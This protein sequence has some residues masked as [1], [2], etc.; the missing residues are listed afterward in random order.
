MEGKGTC[1][2]GEPDHPGVKV[3]MEKSG[4]PSCSDSCSLGRRRVHT[5]M[6]DG[7][8]VV[9]VTWVPAGFCA[10]RLYS[11]CEAAC[12]GV[13]GISE[14]FGGW[15]T[16]PGSAAPRLFL[17]RAGRS[18]AIILHSDLQGLVQKVQQLKP[19]E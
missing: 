17:R 6:V 18:R 11:Y 15:V 4:R 19:S 12:D 3:K 10:R 2:E 5:E 16:Q 7:E 9:A 14:A 1:W 13:E 8:Q